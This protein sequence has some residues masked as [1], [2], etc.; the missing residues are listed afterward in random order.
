MRDIVYQNQADETFADKKDVHYG[1]M[2][3]TT[4]ALSVGFS[5]LELLINYCDDEYNAL[6]VA[7]LAAARE[8]GDALGAQGEPKETER[9]LPMTKEKMKQEKLFLPPP[10]TREFLHQNATAEFDAAVESSYRIYIDNDCGAAA[11]NRIDVLD[12]S[13]CSQSWISTPGNF[14]SNKISRFMKKYNTNNDGWEA[15]RQSKEGWSNKD[16]WV[17]TKPNATFTLRFPSVE[18][19]IKTV[20]IYF[21][22]SY[23][24]KWKDSSA[25]FTTLR[26]PPGATETASAT[27]KVVSEYDIPG[28]HA[29]ENFTYSLT[30]S[31]TMRLSETVKKGETVDIKVDLVFGSHFKIMGMMLCNK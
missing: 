24:E 9:D 27:S 15:E 7:A 6:A 2:A 12:K 3:H 14:D 18:K 29:D 4:I 25:R 8:D 5:A 16:G 30:L 22:R 1:H 19:E 20:S 23:G 28:I 17:A 26:L 11:G 31:E 10:L 21:L 13:P